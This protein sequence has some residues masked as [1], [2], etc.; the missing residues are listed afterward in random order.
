MKNIIDNVSDIRSSR[1]TDEEVMTTNEQRSTDNPSLWER[2]GPATNFG[3][4]EG[5]GVHLSYIC[6][7]DLAGSVVWTQKTGLENMISESL[8][9]LPH[10][11]EIPQIYDIFV[12]TLCT[13]ITFC[14]GPWGTDGFQ[15]EPNSLDPH[16]ILSVGLEV[17]W[18][19]G[20]FRIG[21]SEGSVGEVGLAEVS[22]RKIDVREVG[23]GETSASEV[24][25]RQ[26]DC[27]QVSVR[28]VGTVEGGVSAGAHD[29]RRR[30][31]CYDFGC[32]QDGLHGLYNIVLLQPAVILHK[33]E[34]REW[35]ETRVPDGFLHVL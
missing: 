34:A 1:V 26:V 3:L 7:V 25:V 14:T 29:N 17:L 33:P 4:P 16:A 31:S 18:Q 10:E 6:S 23:T 28:E 12:D 13:D 20:V 35:C 32:T 30:H 19:G 2:C 9:T 8:P 11:Y 24:G 21:A 5:V 22:A 27:T 15:R